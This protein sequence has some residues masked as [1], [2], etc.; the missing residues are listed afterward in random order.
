MGRTSNEIIKEIVPD[1]DLFVEDF[2]ESPP[3]NNINFDRTNKRYKFKKRTAENV[4]GLIVKTDRDGNLIYIETKM[5]KI[6]NLDIFLVYILDRPDTLFVTFYPYELDIILKK[7]GERVCS[8]L[9]YRGQATDYDRGVT[10]WY[11]PNKNITIQRMRR[12][13]RIQSIKDWFKNLTL[14]DA[15]TDND[16]KDQGVTGLTILANDLNKECMLVLGSKNG[17]LSAPTTLTNS[18][19]ENANYRPD[20]NKIPMEA[21]ELAYTSFHAPWIEMF[22]MGH[23]EEIHDYDL[24]SAYPTEVADLI[25]I[26]TGEWVESDTFQAGAYYGFCYAVIQIYPTYIS[27]ILMR[28]EGKLFSTEGTWVGTITKDEIDFIQRHE[29]GNV[30][31]LNGWWY[32]PSAY[33]RPFKKEVTRLLKLRSWAKLKGYNLLEYAIK[34]ST[35]RLAGKFLQKSINLDDLQTYNAGRHFNPIYATIVMTRVKLSLAEQLFRDKEKILAIV[36][37]GA[38]LDG[39]STVS[40]SKDPGDL[41][42]SEKG[43]G[44]IFSPFTTFLTENRNPFLVKDIIQKDPM[45]TWYPLPSFGPDRLRLCQAILDN[46]FEWTGRIVESEAIVE[47]GNTNDRF[48]EDKPQYGLDLLLKKYSSFPHMIEH[49][50]YTY[51]VADLTKQIRED[52]LKEINP[53]EVT[54]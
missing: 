24:N 9:I 40:T 2:Y 35:A 3:F 43:D 11:A 36:I 34:T 41:K 15:L 32:F 50:S 42:L 48:W 33:D 26:D 49:F 6:S 23:F 29:L 14:E 16:I 19:L 25:S 52:M 28:S 37:D 12:V 38:L 18:I 39:K 21:I 20:F 54:I 31:V 13:V 44:V 45:K 4:E 10:M 30:V 17:D 7:F 1:T 46:K 5:G 8:R 22:R 47:V 51:G 53:Q 27:P